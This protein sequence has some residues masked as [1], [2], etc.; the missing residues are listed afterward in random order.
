MAIARPDPKRMITNVYQIIITRQAQKQI[1]DLP[2]SVRKKIDK[3]ILGLKLQPRPDGAI[4]LKGDRTFYRIRV[5]NYRI[6]YTIEDAELNAIVVK[7]GDRME[8]Y[9]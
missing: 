6:L 5:G 2:V 9:E 8:V 3:A 7:V 1:A 4:R